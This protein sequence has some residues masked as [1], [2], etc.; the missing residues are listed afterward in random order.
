MVDPGH[1]GCIGRGIDLQAL[2]LPLQ[3]VAEGQHR[4]ATAGHGARTCQYSCVVATERLRK[5][6]DH[7]PGD[8][9]ML[10][11]AQQGQ[12]SGVATGITHDEIELFAHFATLFRQV[13]L[14]PEVLPHPVVA[15]LIRQPARTVTT[16]VRNVKNLESIGN[17]QDLRG[18][19]GRGK[20]D[21]ARALGRPLRLC[22]SRQGHEP[23]CR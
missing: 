16:I 4:G 9:A 22:S 17:L 8:V 5:T 1:V 20:I 21:A 6:I 14:V 11:S 10:L 15:F 13:L 7:P 3:L 12:L 18:L 19:H 2:H 23:R